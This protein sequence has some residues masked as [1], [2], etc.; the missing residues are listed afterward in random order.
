LTPG[1]F[2]DI[3]KAAVENCSAGALLG[4]RFNHGIAESILGKVPGKL[5][6]NLALAQQIAP[7]LAAGLN[8]NPRQCKR[9]LNTVVVRAEMAAARKVELKRRVLAKLMLLEYFRPES[10]KKLAEAQAEQAGKPDEL[11]AAEK[12]ATPSPH[13]QAKPAPAPVA[14]SAD[15]R[16]ES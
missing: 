1:Q 4:V 15:A 12:T 10:F 13:A 16:G 5:A 2:D 11:S 14:P 7:I 6:D 9:F 8:G 3:R